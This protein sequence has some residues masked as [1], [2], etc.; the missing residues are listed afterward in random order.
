MP[1]RIPYVRYDLYSAVV[2]PLRSER[3]LLPCSAEAVA[4]AE[5]DNVQEDY[6]QQ[7]PHV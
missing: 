4:V 6:L 5:A 7:A 3:K 1:E 2:L